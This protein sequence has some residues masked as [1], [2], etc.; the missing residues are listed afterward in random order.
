MTSTTLQRFK[1]TNELSAW[2]QGKGAP[3]VLIHGVG[4]NADA[5]YAMAPELA[6]YFSV[7]AIDLPGH[8]ESRLPD[9]SSNL[10]I[11]DYTAA[12][13]T[14]LE[15]IDGPVTVCGHSLGALVAIDLAIQH[16][17]KVSSAIALNSIFHRSSEAAKAVRARAQ[18]LAQGNHSDPTATL[19]RWFGAQPEEQHVEARDK[20]AAM[21]QT[22]DK[23]G[24]A[25]AYQVFANQDGPAD[26]ALSACGV[27]ML[28]ITGSN[29]PN[30]T[31]QMSK[32]LAATAQNG[33]HRI[34]ENA[35][36]MM[37]IT[38]ADKVN[39]HILQFVKEGAS[40][41]G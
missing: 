5:W 33:Q 28:F 29:E 32:N 9:W 16:P 31:P 12:L 4:L 13:F 41:N 6:E 14:A 22:V 26:E 2:R 10:S 35:R 38:H 27:P 30:S 15:T 24:Y 19:E 7:T 39:Q 20:C 18:E 8:G 40:Q 3:I 36:H 1:V 17:A 37:P 34:I 11:T 21:L 23:E 25:A